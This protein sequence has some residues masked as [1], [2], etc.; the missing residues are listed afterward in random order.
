MFLFWKGEWRCGVIW[1]KK[2]YINTGETETESGSAFLFI[3]I[4]LMSCI[5]W[6]ILSAV[7]LVHFF[8][9][10]GKTFLCGLILL[11]KIKGNVDPA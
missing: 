3:M 6:C 7:F 9:V 8:W 10:K 4:F 2:T 1:R 5:V 11:Y